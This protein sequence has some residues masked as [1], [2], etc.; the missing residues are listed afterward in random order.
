MSNNVFKHH[1]CT[2]NMNT[3]HFCEFK[4]I[5][6]SGSGIILKAILTTIILVSR[7]YFKHGFQYKPFKVAK[8][9]DHFQTVA[10]SF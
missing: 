6:Y 4:K 8:G 10:V 9:R 5:S 7:K 3:M 2:M 1:V